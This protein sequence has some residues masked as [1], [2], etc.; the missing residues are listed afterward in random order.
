MAFLTRFLTSPLTF[1]FLPLPVFSFPSQ[2]QA[3][4]EGSP[5]FAS[6]LQRLWRAVFW[7]SSL[8]PPD[9]SPGVRV[10]GFSP[11][12]IFPFLFVKGYLIIP[13]VFGCG[14]LCFYFPSTE[15]FCFAFSV[16]NRGTFFF[17]PVFGLFCS[18]SADV[19]RGRDDPCPPPIR[20]SERLPLK[21]HPVFPSSSLIWLFLIPPGFQIFGCAVP[22]VGYP[23]PSLTSFPSPPLGTSSV[24][25]FLSETR[26]RHHFL[27]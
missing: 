21:S 14:V 2:R 20:S 3:R 25:N 5:P 12:F 6:G 19:R 17:S 13:S 9:Y 22:S 11:S 15:M 8:L 10:P 1:P 23:S 4:F 27:L 16:P 7:L 26:A 18:G 24:M